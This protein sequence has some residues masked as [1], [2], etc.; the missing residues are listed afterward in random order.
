[1]MNRATLPTEKLSR[2]EAERSMRTLPDKLASSFYRFEYSD[3]VSRLAECLVAYG[4][5]YFR[6]SESIDGVTSH[7]SRL[8]GFVNRLRKAPAIE[9]IS[10]RNPT[11]VAAGFDQPWLDWTQDGQVFAMLRNHPS[12]IRQKQLVD[13]LFD[14]NPVNC[15]ANA[16]IDSSFDPALVVPG[17]DGNG[18]WVLTHSAR[19]AVYS[20][21]Q[22]SS[23]EQ[24]IVS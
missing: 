1:M 4:P 24:E 11:A 5:V 23:F 7:G 22:S 14:E 13:L 9:I 12:T 21:F 3:D 15:L 20:H 16:T 8:P 6:T 2:L 10:S 17:T 18:F 19:H